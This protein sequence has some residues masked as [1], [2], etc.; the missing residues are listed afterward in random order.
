MSALFKKPKDMRWVDLAIWVDENFYK[1]DCDMNTAYTYIY[2]LASMLASKRRYF[3]NQK[4][5]DEFASLLA[6]DTFTRM[7]NVKKGKIK[8]V[9]NYM[10]SIIS[11]RRIGYNFQKR[12]KIID[13]QYDPE[14]DAM[15][16]VE[17]CKSS[18]EASMNYRVYEGV[19]SLLNEVP[20]IIINNIPRVYKIDKAQYLNIY[21]SCLLSMISSI[22]LPNSYNDK[23]SK[24]QDK[25]TGFDEVKYYSKYL[26]DDIILW[27][28]H[29]DLKDLIKVILNKTK[30][31]LINEIKELSSDGRVSDEEFS[32]IMSSGFAGVRDEADN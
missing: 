19:S 8:S 6:Y 17:K 2:L 27:H 5:Y 9:L 3:D 31:Q 25:S 24:K 18:Y 30:N 16:Y 13:P 28:L 10:K 23:F 22:T 21:I 4:D 26:E 14:W 1:E 20:S 11:F 32:K 12:Q 7:Q 29:D 15:S